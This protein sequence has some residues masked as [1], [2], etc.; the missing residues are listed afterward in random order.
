MALAPISQQEAIDWGV[1]GP[2]LRATGS[3]WDIRKKRPYGGYDQFEFEVPTAN[4]GDCY[5]RAQLRIEEMRESL[6]IIRQCLDNMPEGPYKSDHPQPR[7]R[8]KSAPWRI[9]KP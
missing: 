9:L 5:D 7:R 2:G 3:D 1:T 4:N 6:K 8:P